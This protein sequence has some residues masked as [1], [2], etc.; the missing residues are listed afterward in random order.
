[1][2]RS[3]LARFCQIDYDREMALIAL[4]TAEAGDADAPMLGEVRAACDPDNQRA[5]FAIQVA[6]AWQRKG[7]GRAMLERMLEHL[8]ARGVHE[9]WGE[10]LVDN[11]GMASLA[12][13]LGFSVKPGAVGGV[14]ALQRRLD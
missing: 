10:C 2:P 11:T 1:V 13:E 7:L 3:E 5:E 6:G 4:S 12:R 8:R 9:V 14:Y